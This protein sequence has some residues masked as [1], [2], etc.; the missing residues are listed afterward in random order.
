MTFWRSRRLVALLTLAGLALYPPLSTA[1]HSE[2]AGM[3]SHPATGDCTDTSL[4]CALFATPHVAPDGSLWVVWAAANRI[5]VAHS[6]DFGGTFAAP[7]EITRGAARLDTGSDE[8][9]QLVVDRRGRIVVSYAL[10]RDERYNG[11]VMVAHSTN[12]GATFSAPRPI[13]DS[14]AS[15]RFVT[16]TLDPSDEVFAAWIDKRNVVKAQQAG[17][18]FAGASLAF[19]W[20]TDGGATFSPAQIA[21]DQLCECCRLGVTLKGPRQPVILFRNIFAGER[22]HA[23][24]A[25]DTATTPGAVSRVSE[26]HWAID[27]CPHHGPSLA[28]GP[29]GTHHAAWFSG[30][31]VRKGLFYGRSTD[32]G[33]TFSAPASIGA[34]GRQ[35]TRPYV[36]TAGGSVW[37][38]WKEFDGE[39]ASVQVMQSKDDG[40]TWSTPRQVAGTGDF[41]DHPMLIA[42]GGAAYLS[43]LT[44][45]EGYRAIPLEA[46][47]TLHL[48]A[49]GS[50]K[51]IR[52]R[53]VGKPFIA[54]FWGLTCPPC[55]G[56]LPHWAQLLTDHPNLAVVFVAADPVPMEGDRLTGTLAKAGLGQAE[57]W[58]F[59]NTFVDPL[60]FEVSPEWAGE[61]PYTLLVGKDGA[62]TTL[63]GVA[64]LTA[65]RKWITAQSR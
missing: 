21:H 56:E 34:A 1:Q 15:Q 49:R 10:F 4:K 54:H 27:A 35:P 17:Q 36:L 33:R 31:G 14:L 24:L 47:T 6:T 55:L 52:E 28:V 45:A 61:L 30:G 26:D 42:R 12:G 39:R 3:G 51:T 13:S 9:P 20:S 23:V 60:R 65:V 48:F 29:T 38:A 7:V 37:L 5:F 40:R 32:G 62:V 53:H 63:V 58:V 44:R 16:L 57:Q 46:E 43:W 64:D 18:A 41:S 2:Q 25:F 8:R 11:Q 22:D 50:W 59:N 19:A